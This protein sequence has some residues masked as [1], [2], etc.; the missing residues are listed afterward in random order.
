MTLLISDMSSTVIDSFKKTTFFFAD[1]TLLLRK[2]VWADFM[3]THPHLLAWLRRI[4]DSH[5]RRKR[6]RQGM[7]FSTT[8]DADHEKPQSPEQ[9]HAHEEANLR[10]LVT[11]ITHDEQRLPS[12][13]KMA[14]RLALAIRTVA[15]HLRSDADR[16]YSFEEWAELTRLIRFTSEPPNQALADQEADVIEWDWLGEQSPMMAGVPETEFVLDRL[17]ES[18]VRYMGK[19]EHLVKST[20]REGLSLKHEI[21]EVEGEGE[22]HQVGDGIKRKG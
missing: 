21:A 4:R 1:F 10:Q 9:A 19:V 20:K 5:A 16:T 12:E 18:L 3:K 13:A 8:A 17:C 2:G 14:R 22:R 7:L 15:T 6:L 11:E